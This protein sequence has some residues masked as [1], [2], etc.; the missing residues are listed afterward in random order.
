LNLTR[1]KWSQLIQTEKKYLKKVLKAQK[2]FE[3]KDYASSI[4]YS[5][6]PFT[7]FENDYIYLLMGSSYFFREDYGPSLLNLKKQN[8]WEIE[9]LMRS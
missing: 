7:N 3:Q 2:S 8:R 9:V 6:P 5:K 1:E 4:N